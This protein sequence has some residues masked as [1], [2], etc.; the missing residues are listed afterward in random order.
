M[1]ER[2]KI[3]EELKAIAPRLSEI[4]PEFD[5][6]A[7]PRDYFRNLPEHVMDKINQH[8]QAEKA[9]IAI[10]ERIIAFLNGLLQPRYALAYATLAVLLVGSLFLFKNKNSIQ[11]S[12]FSGIELK[13]VPDEDIFTY[14][15]ENIAD[16]ETHT[17]N[18]QNQ[19]TD[20]GQPS[21]DTDKPSSEE[22]EQ[23]LYDEIEKIDFAELQEIL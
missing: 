23:Y 9:R 3:L 4:D 2:E 6:S 10:P 22:M 14:I 1:K 7:V 20:F 19:Y 8:H 5:R 18:T 13:D 11:E 17:I 12:Y 15:S 21:D 16:Y